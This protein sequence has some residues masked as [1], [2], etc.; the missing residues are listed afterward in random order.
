MDFTFPPD[1]EKFR[2]EV[3]RFLERELTPEIRDEYDHCTDYPHGFNSRISQS[4]GQQGWLTLTWPTEVGGKGA[5]IWER[6]AFDEE[7]AAAH[8]PTAAHEVAA[9]FAGPSLV[10]F[11]T[12][13]QKQRLLPPITRGESTW[14]IGLTEPNAGTDLAAIEL[15]ARRDGDAW[16]FNGSKM[17]TEHVQDADRYFVLARTDPEAPKHRGIS[18]FVIDPKT[19][20]ITLVPLWTMDG[21]RLNQ[22]FFDDAR[23]PADSLVGEENRGFYHLVMTLNTRRASF[24]GAWAE[25]QRDLDEL[26]A[27]SHQTEEDGVPLTEDGWA[28]Q[29]I[30]DF[31]IH[32]RITRLLAY[33]VATML[34][35]GGPA[36]DKE[37]SVQRVWSKVDGQEPIR[38]ASELMGMAGQV[39]KHSPEHAP[40]KARWQLRYIGGIAGAHNGGTPENILNTVAVRVLG[41][42]R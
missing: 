22:V 39:G 29:G 8:C 36:S 4:L 27:F 9:N 41:L 25:N 5:S 18:I 42:P 17:F 21:Y 12:E 38:F 11:G 40:L 19:P 32:T 16:V 3:R 13:D 34:E 31:A 35:G 6:L 1:V 26:V 28:Q 2:G 23:V 10:H 15:R 7:M 20:G 30:A 37:P 33:K 14:A 24:L